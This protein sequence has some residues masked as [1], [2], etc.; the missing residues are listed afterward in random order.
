MGCRCV[1]SGGFIMPRALLQVEVSTQDV[2]AAAANVVQG[3][4]HMHKLPLCVSM[5]P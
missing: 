4:L 3:K 2:F 1:Q 5:Q